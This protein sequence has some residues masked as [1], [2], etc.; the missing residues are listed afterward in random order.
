MSDALLQV[1]GLHKHF[2]VGGGLLQA[3]RRLRAVDGVDLDV[4]VGETVG[5]R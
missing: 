3:K 1:R 4:H 5:L 2:P